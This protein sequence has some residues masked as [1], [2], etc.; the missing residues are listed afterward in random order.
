MKL[1]IDT[2]SKTIKVEGTVSLL[3]LTETLERLLPNGVWKTFSLETNVTIIWNSPQVI[4]PVVYPVWPY[5]PWWWSQPS[6]ITCGT[7]YG[8]ANAISTPPG[9]EY[10]LTND[11]GE[12]KTYT[13]AQGTY[14]IEI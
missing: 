9:T 4:Q 7:G 10:T 3:E 2:T 11:C 14:N 1:Q 5:Y 6:I 12:L 13:L 8:N